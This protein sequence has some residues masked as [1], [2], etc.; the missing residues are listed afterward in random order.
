[1]PG[2]QRH[3]ADQLGQLPVRQ[4]L[5]QVG[6]EQIARLALDLVDMLDE[7]VERAVLRD[8][9]GRG[10][11]T[12]AGNVRQVVR[13]VATQRRVVGVLL[14]SQA[15]LLLHHLRRRADEVGYAADAGRG[16]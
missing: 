10:L 13:R 14:R 9:P 3:V 7:L 2:L 12:H 15:V 4:H 16:R 5:R 6:A 1:M 11:L 8:P